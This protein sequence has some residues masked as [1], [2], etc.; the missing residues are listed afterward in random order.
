VAYL[1]F[2]SLKRA[3]PATDEGP[4]QIIRDQA[5]LPKVLQSFMYSLKFYNS[6]GRIVSEVQFGCGWLDRELGQIKGVMA[7]CTLHIK[8]RPL[9]LLD[10]V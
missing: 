1:V 8:E 10:S 5:L 4:E 3:D 2:T 9:P 6:L 7:F